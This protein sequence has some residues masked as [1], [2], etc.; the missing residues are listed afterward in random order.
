M[1]KY[2]FGRAEDY[3][4]A[5]YACLFVGELNDS[6]S[7]QSNQDEL[8][9]RL[10]GTTQILHTALDTVG[11]L[12]YEHKAHIAMLADQEEA[13]WGIDTVSELDAALA[14]S[15]AVIRYA[16]ERGRWP[17]ALVIASVLREAHNNWAESEARAKVG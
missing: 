14:V 8:V 3:T 5:Y 12:F 10:G 15:N 1:F 9:S 16:R 2:K 17:S 11:Q 6:L 4:V 7:R 13:V